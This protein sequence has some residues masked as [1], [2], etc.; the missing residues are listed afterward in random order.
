[1]AQRVSVPLSARQVGNSD[2][3][4]IRRCGFRTI[5]DAPS[6]RVVWLLLSSGMLL[7]PGIPVMVFASDLVIS[8]A[9]TAHSPV[10][11]RTF[12]SYFRLAMT[13]IPS[14]APACQRR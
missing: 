13:G 9:S 12:D 8:P 4:M 5:N 1:M 3:G 11:S 14:T 10:R 6:S 7:S 2:G